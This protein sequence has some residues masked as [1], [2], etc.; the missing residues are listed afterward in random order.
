MN[1]YLVR[2]KMNVPDYPAMGTLIHHFTK[3]Y[4]VGPKDNGDLCIETVAP[5][6]TAA[7]NMVTRELTKLGYE[8]QQPTACVI[9]RN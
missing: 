2:V 9:G 6:N 1:T 5:D 4:W 8:Y 7:I 3:A